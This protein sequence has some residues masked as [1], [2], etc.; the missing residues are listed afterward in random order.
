MKNY[1]VWYENYNYNIYIFW[2]MKCTTQ[3]ID[4]ADGT[5]HM[6]AESVIVILC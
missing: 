6:Q 3:K 2:I 1:N 4:N 5:M